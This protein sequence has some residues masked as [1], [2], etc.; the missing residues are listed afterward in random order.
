MPNTQ[1]IDYQRFINKLKLK[2]VRKRTLF[3]R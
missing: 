2:S 1:I 3:V